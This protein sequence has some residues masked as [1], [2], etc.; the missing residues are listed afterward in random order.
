MDKNGN[1]AY[2]IQATIKSGIAQL[3]KQKEAD[4]KKEDV[5]VD[6]GQDKLIALK[7]LGPIQRR[8][9]SVE[10]PVKIETFI[11]LHEKQVFKLQKELDSVEN[12]NKKKHEQLEHL[13]KELKS[14][15]KQY[16]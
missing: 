12:E 4:L 2:D 14:V 11:K 9:N 3:I 7:Q 8:L 16:K 5:N 10:N 13:K 6:A 1:S 15:K